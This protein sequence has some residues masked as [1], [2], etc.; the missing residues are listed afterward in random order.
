MP[1]VNPSPRQPIVIIMSS[2]KKYL[3]NQ[4]K[5]SQYLNL[6]P[7]NLLQLFNSCKVFLATTNKLSPLERQSILELYFYL[8]ILTNHDIEAKSTLQKLKESLPLTS[9]SEK[10]AVLESYYLEAIGSTNTSSSTSQEKKD[11]K[12]VSSSKKQET[13]LKELEE[14]L[15][16]VQTL[17]VN[18]ENKS[19]AMSLT[20]QQAGPLSRMTT[21][22]LR[23]IV[24]RKVALHKSFSSIDTY[25]NQLIDFLQVNTMDP[26]TWNEL[27]QTYHKLG[28]L[29]KAH[30]CFMEIA[31][32]Q[33]LN[34]KNWL[35]LADLEVELFYS[36]DLVAFNVLN[37]S[38]LH[39][40]RAVELCEVLVDAWIGLV[41]ALKL[42]PVSEME[43]S[44]VNSKLKPL[45]DLK[46][47]YDQLLKLAAK[48][49]NKFVELGLVT[50]DKKLNSVKAVLDDT[51]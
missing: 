47:K 16:Q 36:G 20:S 17:I 31:V 35:Q 39:Y 46:G 11:A 32:L 48:K 24:K 2:N 1:I 49:V 19:R 15:T 6:S 5:T 12:Q 27:G 10:L 14:Y 18:D 26:F 21:N 3:L 38:I 4:Y 40:L 28:E 22:D 9:K 29:T 37:D 25:V 23:T 50:D 41:V 8:S 13:I 43:K 44:G 42:I 7:P 34:Y 30:S 33:P 51:K 45:E